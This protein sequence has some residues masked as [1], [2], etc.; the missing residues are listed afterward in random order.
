[1]P[2]GTTV[3]EFKIVSSQ[4]LPW[5]G[6]CTTQNFI[7]AVILGSSVIL[8]LDSPRL[9]P[10]SHL[11]QAVAVLDL[12]FTVGHRTH[13]SA[14]CTAPSVPVALPPVKWSSG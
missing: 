9:D 6:T 4:L 1:M 11:G 13:G 14:R 2:H 5:Y 7:L 10:S 3:I 12:I 8:A